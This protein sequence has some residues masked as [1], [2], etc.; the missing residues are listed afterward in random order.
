[1][2]VIRTHIIRFADGSYSSHDTLTEMSAREA[3][4][5]ESSDEPNHEYNIIPA[6]LARRYVARG[7]HHET[8]LYVNENGHVRYA[9][10]CN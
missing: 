7:M 2:Y 8:P 4:K 1:M 6:D 3:R 10:D 9:R 5:A